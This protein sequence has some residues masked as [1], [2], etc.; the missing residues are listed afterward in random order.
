VSPAALRRILAVSLL[1]LTALVGAACG[2]SDESTADPAA[3]APARAPAYVEV[4]VALEGKERE[5]ALAAA[6][7]VLG[8]D[9]P[10]DAL[11][12]MLRSPGD[13]DPWLGDRIGAF[14]QPGARGGAGL[15]AAVSD[16]DAAR[17]WVER[18]GTRTERHR[19]TEIRLGDAGDAFAVVDD[20][21]VTGPPAAVKAAIDAAE[22][23]ALADADAFEDALDRVQGPDGIGR[24][25]LAPRALLETQVAGGAA[26]GM[27]GSLAVGALTDAL[28]T[29]AGAKLRANG[30]R[31]LA[32][33]ATIGGARPGQPP[34]P[35][36]L[37]AVTGTAWLAAGLGNVG[38]R[39]KASLGGSE[40]LLGLVGAQ[41][42]LDLDREL[43]GWMGDGTF[44]LT[45]PSIAQPRGAL[46]VA[47]T[48]PAATRAVIPKLGALVTRFAP[49]ATVRTLR[50]AGVDAG[51]TVRVQGVPAP[52]H[53]AAAGD[54]FVVAAGQQALREA[55][56]PSS[57]LGD[58]PDFRAA[59]ATLGDGLRPTVF[60]RARGA[61]PLAGG[62]APTVERFSAL[63]ASDRGDG[64]WRTSLALR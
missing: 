30:S 22:G 41:A 52:V 10:A 31:I 28:P 63:V 32:D 4:T 27:F 14:L 3:V 59:A 20:R 1:A 45:G 12:R 62:S 43:L 2:S 40:A 53:V 44:V 16:G 26:G 17:D 48:D 15:V 5:D 55:I 51:I 8:T 42:G 34:D 23:D 56:D 37:A 21:V 57:R 24:A 60:V 25:Y 33:V 47:S 18:Q 38:E 7:K 64:R 29:A 35:E 49:G 61:A 13:V 54:R 11:R 9:D 36:D 50:A 58:D 39:L 19:D 6:R 46:V